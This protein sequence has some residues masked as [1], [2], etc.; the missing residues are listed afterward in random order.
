MSIAGLVANATAELT[1]LLYRSCQRQTVTQT[2]S[3]ET[4]ANS[5]AAFACMYEESSPAAQGALSYEA[6]GG[7][8]YDVWT[9]PT[10]TILNSDRIVV[11]GIT[12]SVVEATPIGAPG[13]LRRVRTRRVTA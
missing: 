3:G 11:D 1:E 2:T 4:W 8:G 13:P 9:L 12:L 10:Q 6:G 5:G 7:F